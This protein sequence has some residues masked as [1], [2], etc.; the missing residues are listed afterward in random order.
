MSVEDVNKATAFTELLAVD[1]V[2]QYCPRALRV[3]EGFSE[4]PK[5]GGGG[6]REVSESGDHLRG[7]ILAISG[8]YLV[9][10]TDLAH[11]DVADKHTVS[12]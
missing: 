8:K 7:G 3:L 5:V 11:H 2:M 6:F 4:I 10:P 9:R 1:I 12:A